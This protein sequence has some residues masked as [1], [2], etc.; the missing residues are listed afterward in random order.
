[1]LKITDNKDERE[2]FKDETVVLREQGQLKKALKQFDTIIAWDDKNSNYRGKMDVLGHKRLTL[3]LMAEK[4]K[5]K[6]EKQELYAKATECIENALGLVGADPR[7]TE[8]VINRQ[9]IHLASALLDESRVNSG[10]KAG[11]QRKYASEYINKALEN[12]TG[13]EANKAWVL[14]VKADI[15][16]DQGY[17]SEAIQTLCSAQSCLFDGYKVAEIENDQIDLKYNVWVAGIL[18]R[19][20]NIAKK[21]NMP[22]LAEIFGRIVFNMDDPAGVLE[23][24]KQEAGKLLK[25]S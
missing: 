9:K 23:N 2:K 15:L 14:C 20:A 13:T 16:F 19:M 8:D 12:Y 24:K 3:K 11:L 6:H 7:I 22:L 17:V 5:S 18:L 21:E 4:A 1:M 25:V 10:S